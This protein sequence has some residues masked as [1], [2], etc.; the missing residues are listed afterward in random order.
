MVGGIP[1]PFRPSGVTSYQVLIIP[2]PS[3]EPATLH[4]LIELLFDLAQASLR[5]HAKAL[6]Y[7]TRINYFHPA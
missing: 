5:Y 1:S 7:V 4:Q 2:A 3:D 6:I